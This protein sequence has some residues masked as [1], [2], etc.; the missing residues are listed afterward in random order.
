MRYL[1]YIFLLCIFYSANNIA[2]ASTERSYSIVRPDSLRPHLGNIEAR[3]TARIYELPDEYKA[4]K[5]AT[6]QRRW[7]QKAFDIIIREPNPPKDAKHSI[8]EDYT[9]Y[10]GKIIRNITYTRLKPFGTN[11]INP[12]SVNTKYKK[13][14]NLHASTKSSV[15]RRM[16][17]FKRGDHLKAIMLSES[18]TILRDADY[19]N[20]ARI[21]VIPLGHTNDSVDIQVITRDKWTMGVE[22]HRLTSK[23]TDIELFDKNLFG[24]GNRGSASLIY[25]SRYS[26][27]L[28]FGGDY[29]FRNIGKTSIDIGA[30][31][32]D[33]VDSREMSYIAE[34]RLRPN[35]NYFGK[36]EYNQANYRTEYLVWDS[37]SPDYTQNFKVALGR[38]FTLPSQNTIKRFVISAMFE[39]KQPE[40]RKLEHAQHIEDRLLPYRGIQNKIWLGQLTLYENSYMRDYMIHNFGV[41]EDVAQGYNISLQGGYSK[42]S[43]PGI[44]DATY[45]SLRLSY[46]TH[47]MIQGYLFSEFTLSSFFSKKK[48]YES[49]I[50]YKLKYYSRLVKLPFGRFRQLITFRYTKMLSPERYFYNRIHLGDYLFCRT[51]DR[52]KTRGGVEQIWLRLENNL[53]SNYSVAGFRFMMYNFMDFGYHTPKND[54]FNSR[55]MFLGAGIGIRIRNDLLVFRSIDIKFGYYPKVGPYDQNKAFDVS[56]STPNVSPRFTPEYPEVI[57]M[58]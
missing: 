52:D 54:L 19:I 5:R 18:E 8:S 48:T 42:Y 31:Y 12:D 21:N 46:G 45:A 27:K 17:Q 11:V 23:R 38:A 1:R 22:L 35:M 9:E 25:S 7:T 36:I 10:E 47:R 32:I 20:D 33:K 30:K 3:D 41:T 14:N 57:L 29:L 13:F 4:V 51:R 40:Y 44:P 55:N 34:R 28:R 37:I 26:G 39:Q 58:K 53:F 56:T 15:I 49:L 50:D 2:F 6:S 43:T 24:Y 16:L